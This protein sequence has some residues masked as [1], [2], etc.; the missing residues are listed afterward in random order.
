MRVY[1]DHVQIVVISQLILVVKVFEMFVNDQ[2]IL[3][4]VFEDSRFSWW[5]WNW[6]KNK[7]IDLLDYLIELVELPHL[8]VY[9]GIQDHGDFVRILPEL[10][11]LFS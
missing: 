6:L 8:R 9:Y 7:S 5:I 11:R 1:I 3:H 10:V 4:V 2:A